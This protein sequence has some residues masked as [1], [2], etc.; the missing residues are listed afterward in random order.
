MTGHHYI[1][2]L[3]KM[4]GALDFVEMD[5][6]RQYLLEKTQHMIVGGFGKL[7][8]DLPDIYHAYMGLAALSLIDGHKG[9]DMCIGPDIEDHSKAVYR[10][11]AHTKD[12]AGID[13]TNR[14]LRELDPMLCMS[15]RAREWIE[16]LTWHKRD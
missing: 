2:T 16:A 5:H 10:P 7:P 12:V 6:V 9:S 15:R 11:P 14:T 3:P 13:D 4:L 8:G 1:L